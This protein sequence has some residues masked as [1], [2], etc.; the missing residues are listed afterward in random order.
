VSN[1][2]RALR[3]VVGIPVLFYFYYVQAR[4]IQMIA[5]R[6]YGA[7]CWQSMVG[8]MWVPSVYLIVVIWIYLRH[9]RLI[10]RLRIRR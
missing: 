5:E 8:W 2:K 9:A 6:A 1:F 3:N 7:Q 4:Y 10:D